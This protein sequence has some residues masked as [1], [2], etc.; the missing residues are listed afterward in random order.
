MSRPPVLSFALALAFALLPGTAPG[1]AQAAALE[2]SAGVLSV[3]AM[4]RGLEEPW[5][6]AFLPDG[7]F[8]VTERGGRLTLHSA[9]GGAGQRIRGLP[10]VAASGQGG[11]LDVMVPRDFASSR[12]VWLSFAQPLD[13]G[14]A[15]AVGKGRLSADERRLEG[16]ETLYA[17]DPAGGGRHFGARLVEG[18]DGTVFLTTGDRGTGPEGQEAQ[19]PGRV[20]GKVIRLNRDGTPAT[21]LPGW[22]AGVFSRGHR[23][24]QGA[25]L[26]GQGRLWV[27]DHGARGGDELNRVDEGANYGWPVISYGVNYNGSPI[28]RG[29]A[30]AG[31]EQPVLYWDPSIAPSGLMIYD[32][33]MFPEW[34]GDFFTG[35]LKFDYLARLD[36]GAGLAEERIE[37]PET[38]RV[39]DV[40]QAPDGSIW[41]LS[42]GEGA[43]FRLSRAGA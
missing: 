12:E 7:R 38:A 34:Q 1:P 20:E 21:A 15:T 14:A 33:A 24:M 13:G 39:R 4:A 17:G 3:T 8:L 36:A 10:E 29:T 5:G 18:R 25:A 6:L 22:R 43:V 31:M 40:R 19:D 37:G 30:V 41:F 26:D 27:V 32:G 23:N 16:F 28:G 42:V 11:L 9:G 35:S 2:S